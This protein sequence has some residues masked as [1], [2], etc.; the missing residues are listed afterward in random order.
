MERM[1]H[2]LL[3]DLLESRN[4]PA[5]RYRSSSE[6]VYVCIMYHAIIDATAFQKKIHIWNG[7]TPLH[8]N[9]N[10]SIWYFLTGIDLVGNACSSFCGADSDV[11]D[12]IVFAKGS[13]GPRNDSNLR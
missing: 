12:A 13:R 7:T 9:I 2:V 1:K 8:H 5:F 4:W 10:C 6:Y 3:T 11:P